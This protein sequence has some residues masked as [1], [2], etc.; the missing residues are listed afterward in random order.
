MKAT[1]GII[2]TSCCISINEIKGYQKEVTI[3]YIERRLPISVDCRCVS[4]SHQ[5][6]S[7]RNMS[8]I[9]GQKY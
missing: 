5:K 9:N 7:A 1:K 4:S 8:K 6:H 3:A 2:L